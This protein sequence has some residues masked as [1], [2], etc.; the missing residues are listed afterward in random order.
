MVN[1]NLIIENRYYKSNSEISLKCHKT[2][3]KKRK[4]NNSKPLSHRL[5]TSQKQEQVKNQ[6][7]K[8]QN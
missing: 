4:L 6:K 3:K 1:Y 2:K 5:K 7:K 8:K